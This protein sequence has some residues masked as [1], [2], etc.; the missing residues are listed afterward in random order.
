MGRG[1]GTTQQGVKKPKASHMSSNGDGG[2]IPSFGGGVSSSETSSNICL[3][4]IDL[5]IKYAAG[6]S[7]RMTRGD[8]VTLAR[9]TADEVGVF[10]GNRRFSSYTGKQK[11]LLLE[12]MAKGYVY[13]GQVQSVGANTLRAIVKGGVLGHETLSP[14]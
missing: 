5:R 3:F 10:V 13:S 7:P 2:G 11:D 12:C 6:S 8:T 14:A 4:S 9:I 1:S